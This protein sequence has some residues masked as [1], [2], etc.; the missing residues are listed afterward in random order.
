[1]ENLMGEISMLNAKVTV[2]KKINVSFIVH[3]GLGK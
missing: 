2:F 1:M 3:F